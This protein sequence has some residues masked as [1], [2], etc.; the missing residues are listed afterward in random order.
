[1]MDLVET[2]SQQLSIFQIWRRLYPRKDFHQLSETIRKVYEEVVRF[3]V[4]AICF[5]NRTPPRKLFLGTTTIHWLTSNDRQFCQSDQRAGY[6]S[7]TEEAS[8]QGRAI[9]CSS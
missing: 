1:M 5:L 2:I 7:K 9:D 6:G 3:F 4:E 8:R